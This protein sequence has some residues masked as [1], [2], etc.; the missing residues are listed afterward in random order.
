MD[1]KDVATHEW[2][3]VVGLEHASTDQSDDELTMWGGLQNESRLC[4]AV[5][6]CRWRDTLGL[7][8]ILGVRHLYPT[9]A[10]FPTI[11]YP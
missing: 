8:D 6:V 3:H 11:A 9:S 2:G 1:L 10:P 4:D 5:S 7:G